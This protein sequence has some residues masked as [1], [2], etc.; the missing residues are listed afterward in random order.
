MRYRRDNDGYLIRL[1]DGEEIIA[2]LAKFVLDNDIPGGMFHGLGALDSASIGTYNYATRSYITKVYKDKLDIAVMT[3]NIT[4]SQDSDLP[5]IHCH[6]TVS[7][8]E[9]DTRAGHLFEGIVLIT[10][11]IFLK[12]F[13]E[14]LYR[15]KELQDG[16]HLW[17]L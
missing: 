15:E 13:T 4:Y 12:V 14:K 1:E 9:H 8:S 5:V 2:T 11:E 10:V 3:G 7:D 17:Q 6:I 16:H